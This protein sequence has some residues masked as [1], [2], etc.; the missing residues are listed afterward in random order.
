MPI[1]RVAE[2]VFHIPL[3]PRDGVNAYLLGDVVVDAGTKGA[4]KRLIKALR[5]HVVSAHALTHGHPDHAGGSK[6]LVEAFEVPVWV[7]ERDRADVESGRPAA[8]ETWAR[9][10]VGRLSH[11]EP[12]DVARSL[13]EGD[14]VG[15]GF[16]AL[17]TPGHSD[18]HV[19]FWREGDRTLVVGDVLFN[20]SLLTTAPGLREPPAILTRDPRRNRESAR[21]LAALEPELALFGHGPP[22]RDPAALRA[23][24]DGLGA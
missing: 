9:P 5:G 8:A 4:A 17:E 13:H 19:A 6:R 3:S 21:R 18:G 22:L 1:R 10:V 7:G 24:V 14:E 11:Y 20:L 23:F 15:H 16:V 12:V 2:D